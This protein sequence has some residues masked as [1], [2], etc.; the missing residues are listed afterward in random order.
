[1][2]ERGET[3]NI[4]YD[5]KTDS[6]GDVTEVKVNPIVTSIEIRAFFGW[7]SLQTITLPGTITTVSHYAFSECSSLKSITLPNSITALGNYVF[8]WCTSLTS[9]TLPSTI[10]TLGDYVFS[11]CSSLASIT[12]PSTVTT[13]GNS[14]FY[15][16]SSLTSITLPSTITNI[17]NNVFMLCTSLTSI[18]LPS[19]ITTLGNNDFYGCSSLTSVRLPQNLVSIGIRTFLGCNKLTTI[20]TSSFSTTTLDNNNLDS[21]KSFLLNAGFMTSNPDD[22]ISD[23]QPKYQNL[24]VYYDW[25][26][27]ARTRDVDDRFP[28]FTAAARGL[29][30]SL[31]KQ[32]FISNMPVVNDIDALT[33]LPLFML[34]AIG[35]TSDIES[36]YN[37]LKEYPS[38]VNIINNRHDNHFSE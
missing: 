28:L 34:A 8:M 36:V 37:L 12:L 24:D 22:V 5:I 18:T 3:T 6:Q 7:R 31:V 19:T 25:K 38:V 11:G 17:G 30:W 14:I 23:R 4:S 15:G 20:E 32:I 21:V 29:K 26:R 1:M 13:L 27:W 10:T 35:P 33:G 9:I 2:D 16:C